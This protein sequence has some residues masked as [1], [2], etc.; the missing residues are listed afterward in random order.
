MSEVSEPPQ[1]LPKVLV[2]LA[3]GTEEMEVT[4]TVDI[5]RRGGA[6]VVLAGLE[7]P[8]PVT[9]SRGLRI[10]PDQALADVRADTFDMIVLPG[11]LDGTERFC[12]SA[13]LGRLLSEQEQQG[14]WIAAVCAAPKALVTHGIGGGKAMTSHPSVQDAVAGHGSLSQQRVVH[15]DKLIT[16]Q[17]PGTA[18]EFALAL[19]A[20]L[21]GQDVADGLR[22]PMV[23][24]D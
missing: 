13:E 8:D 9:C 17:G 12:G 4:I 24:A 23:L 22:G 1:G 3:D 21:R 16:S 20:Q 2:L 5:L 18:F 19:V 7:G 6:E 10:V 11:G 15:A 14:R